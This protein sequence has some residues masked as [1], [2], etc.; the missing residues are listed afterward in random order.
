M[1]AR[2]MGTIF[3]ALLVTPAFGWDNFERME[4]ARGMDRECRTGKARSDRFP[5]GGDMGRFY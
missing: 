4:V 5:R 3:C 2:L 1:L